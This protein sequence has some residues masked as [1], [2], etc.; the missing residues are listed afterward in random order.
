MKEMKDQKQSEG[1]QLVHLS[2]PP[3][4]HIMDQKNI[5]KMKYKMHIKTTMK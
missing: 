5:E 1:T 4:D 2:S 3:T